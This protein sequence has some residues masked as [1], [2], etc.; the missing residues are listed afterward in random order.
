MSSK[1]T[2]HEDI[3]VAKDKETIKGRLHLECLPIR[4]VIIVSLIQDEA[5]QAVSKI[6][7]FTLISVVPNP[8]PE[9]EIN[10]DENSTGL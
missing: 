1:L 6:L 5:L 10:F 8:S 7:T 2:Q 3:G 4:Q 9:I